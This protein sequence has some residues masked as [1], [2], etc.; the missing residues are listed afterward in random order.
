MSHM[1][2]I[3]I[4]LLG[5][6]LAMDCFAVSLSKGI[7]ARKLYAAGAATMAVFFG[8]FQAG[9]PLI[10]YFA[11]VHFASFISRVAPWIA[12]VLL[13]F[14]GGKMIWEHFSP[15]DDDEHADADYRFGTVVVLSVAT[16]I[17]AFAVGISFAM[18][19]DFTTGRIAGAVATI[20]AVTAAAAVLG[21][22]GGRRIGDLLGPRCNLIGGCV[23]IAIGIRI[24]IG[25][26]I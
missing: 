7:A 8:L 17:D 15:D 10:G 9:M 25:H 11:G 6:G 16:S 23:L 2:L 19:G 14:I 3:E 1:S 24:L 13:G 22:R 4:I 26:L 21:L 20:A 18:S 5:I 12:L